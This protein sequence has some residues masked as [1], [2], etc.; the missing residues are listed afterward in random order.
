M[1]RRTFN[2]AGRSGILGRHHNSIPLDDRRGR[3]LE[4]SRA[5]GRSAARGLADAPVPRLW[6]RADPAS[7]PAPS[8]GAIEFNLY[9]A[10]GAR[11]RPQHPRERAWHSDQVAT[12]LRDVAAKAEDAG[13]ATTKAP[14]T[15]RMEGLACVPRPSRHLPRGPGGTGA[16]L[17]A[18]RAL[19]AG[20]GAMPSLNG[21]A[22]G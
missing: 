22:R 1:L 5:F 18:R 14:P 3:G 20:W 6:P 10:R 7:A 12:L 11:G 2:G 4:A 19:V 13:P 15:R 17:P 9:R 8:N 16:S 21:R